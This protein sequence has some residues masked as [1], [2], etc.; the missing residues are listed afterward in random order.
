LGPEFHTANL[1][2]LFPQAQPK[3]ATEWQQASPPSQILLALRAE[4][5]TA[6]QLLILEK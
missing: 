5:A 1:L 4:S 2:L 3:P 6:R